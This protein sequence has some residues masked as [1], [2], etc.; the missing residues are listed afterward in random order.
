MVK[1]VLGTFMILLCMQVHA[2]VCD[3]K[4]SNSEYDGNNLLE[5]KAKN[6]ANKLLA[7]KGY[8]ENEDEAWNQFWIGLDVTSIDRRFDARHID[9]MISLYFNSDGYF[10]EKKNQVF[11]GQSN[12]H[13]NPFSIGWK[14]VVKKSLE[15]LQECQGQVTTSTEAKL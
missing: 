11:L 3:Y 2:G 5:L 13:L 4:W 8:I 14:S 10:Y 15:K 9:I 6:Y 7:K 12:S 1:L